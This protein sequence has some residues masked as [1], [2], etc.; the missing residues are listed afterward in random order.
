MWLVT[1]VDYHTLIGQVPILYGL[2]VAAL[3]A[4]I[5][6]GHRREEPNAGCSTF[7]SRSWLK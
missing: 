5:V 4:T 6:L 7:R 3:L 1:S 2:S